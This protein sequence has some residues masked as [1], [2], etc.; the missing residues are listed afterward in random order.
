MIR[1]RN[2]EEAL[3]H[4]YAILAMYQAAAGTGRMLANVYDQN[5]LMPFADKYA[6]H[7]E[8]LAARVRLGAIALDELVRDV[9]VQRLVTDLFAHRGV[10]WQHQPLRSI[11]VGVPEAVDD[12]RHLPSEVHAFHTLSTNEGV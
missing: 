5:T 2:A 11:A 12:P 8:G 6:R 4:A 3:A 10:D 1:Y 9:D 7:Y